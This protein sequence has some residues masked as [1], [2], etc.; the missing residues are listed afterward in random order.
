M[1]LNFILKFFNKW[2]TNL[3]VTNEER[4]SEDLGIPEMYPF[5]V[6]SLK[7]NHFWR[8][9]FQNVLN[10]SGFSLKRIQICI[11]PDESALLW[12]VST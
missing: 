2:K 9:Y 3:F 1:C 5:L 10:S 4:G 11:C 7:N 6:S 12:L 8:K